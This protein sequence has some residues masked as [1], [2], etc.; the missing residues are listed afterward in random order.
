MS[1]APL[2]E[3]GGEG[4]REGGR[5]RERGKVFQTAREIIAMKE[6]VDVFIY[7]HGKKGKERLYFHFI[8]II[9]FVVC[10]L[11]FAKLKIAN[12][13]LAFVIIIDGNNIF[14]N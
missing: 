4:G 14:D 1:D 13:M 5:K 10:L 9:D 6:I 11:G 3:K 2:R 12:I 7:L 8:L